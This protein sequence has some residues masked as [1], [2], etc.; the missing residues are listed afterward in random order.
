MKILVLGGTKFFGKRL[1]HNLLEDGHEVT[2]V[3]RGQT[4][5]DFGDSV[6][7]LIA[8]RQDSGQ[9]AKAIGDSM[10]DVVYDQ[11]GYNPRDAK[12]AVDALTGHVGRFVFTSTGAVYPHKETLITEAD[13]DA[14]S[15][16]I[17]MD[18]ERYEYGE[19]KRQAEAYLF[20]HA[21]FPVVAVRVCMVV[22]GEDDYT[23]RFDFHVHHVAKQISIGVANPAHPITYITARDVAL[24]LRFI[25]TESDFTGSVNVGNGGYYSTQ[26]LCHLIGEVLDVKPIFHESTN[27]QEDKDYSPYAG[28]MTRKFSMER[29]RSIG[30]AFPEL[31]PEIPKMVQLVVE[32]LHL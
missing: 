4:E 21:P 9:L 28:L 12:A 25:G 31:A 16:P 14:Q 19:G 15:Y 18:V 30:Y 13:F 26:D 11:I 27:I 17:D 6:H 3:S 5:D 23:G 7:R 24:F 22:A 32:R 10:Y 29:A 1:V 20:Q 2:V 8:D